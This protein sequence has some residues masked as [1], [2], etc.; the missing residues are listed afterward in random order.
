MNKKPTT[1]GSKELYLKTYDK[2]NFFF[3]Y[4]FL[5]KILNKMV[6]KNSKTKL[7]KKMMTL[8]INLKKKTGNSLLTILKDKLIPNR[9]PIKFISKYTG[10]TKSLIPV[11]SSEKVELKN[12]IN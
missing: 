7:L 10:K 3:T 6:K 8:S 5:N 1:R 2:K 12:V 9:L 11:F 4:A